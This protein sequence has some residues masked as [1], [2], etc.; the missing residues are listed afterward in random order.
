MVEEIWEISGEV[1]MKIVSTSG[2]KFLF[3][4]E[5]FFSYLK[6]WESLNPLNMYFAFTFSQKSIVSP[7]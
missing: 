3:T 4:C 7:S 5:M 2:F 1:I 6:S